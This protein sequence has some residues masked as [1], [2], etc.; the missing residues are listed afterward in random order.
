MPPPWQSAPPPQKSSSS[1]WIIL[2]V[3]GLVLVVVGIPFVVGIVIGVTRAMHRSSAAA[4]TVTSVGPVGPVPSSLSESYVTGNKLLTIHYP[5]DFAAKS[6][7]TGTV[8]VSRNLTGG[9]DEAITFAAIVNPISDDPHELARILIKP[10]ETHVVGKGGTY[11][12]NSERS[13]MCLGKYVGVEVEATFV[14]PPSGPYQ[15]KSCFFVSGTHAYE[16]V[17]NLPKSRLATEGPLIDTIE[18]A[19]ELAP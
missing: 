3:V 8:M 14:L 12:K 2:L 7:D 17:R 5:S 19:T 4:A 13:A 1:T 15:S 18:N 9:D 6:L 10:V 11:T 16:V